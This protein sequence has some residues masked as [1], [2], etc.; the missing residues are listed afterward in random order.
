MDIFKEGKNIMLVFN[1]NL[2]LIKKKKKIN[3]VVKSTIQLRGG[4]SKR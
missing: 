4:K 1:T 2:L 3:K